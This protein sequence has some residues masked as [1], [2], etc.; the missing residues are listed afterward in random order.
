MARARLQRLC[1]LEIVDGLS[2]M[3][4]IIDQHHETAHHRLRPRNLRGAAS[5]RTEAGSSEAGAC[6]SD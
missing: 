2:E 1:V 6:V 3:H 5:K 4:C